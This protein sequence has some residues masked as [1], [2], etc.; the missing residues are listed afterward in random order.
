MGSLRHYKAAEERE[1][2]EK[3]KSR[4]PDWFGEVEGAAPLI[5]RS[6]LKGVKTMED[7]KGENV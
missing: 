3:V 1:G 2:V 7:S 5:R 6:L 4:Q